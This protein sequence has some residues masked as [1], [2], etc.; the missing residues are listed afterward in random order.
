MFF[1]H[2]LDKKFAHLKFLIL[3]TKKSHSKE[4]AVPHP[5]SFEKSRDILDVDDVLKQ[6]ES[7]SPE[8]I[9]QIFGFVE[10]ELGSILQYFSP[11][12]GLLSMVERR[13]NSPALNACALIKHLQ[14][15]EEEYEELRTSLSRRYDKYTRLSMELR[16]YLYLLLTRGSV[17]TSWNGRVGI[18]PVVLEGILDMEPGRQRNIYAA[19]SDL[20]FVDVPEGEYP[21][22]LYLLWSTPFNIDLFLT[23]REMFGIDSDEL[24]RL[25]LD[26]DFTLLDA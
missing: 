6:I 17:T 11:K 2:E 1:A 10:R 23:F 26:G 22:M 19:L 16:E 13:I 8:I 12:Q 24:K 4:F 15:E 20:G 25:L 3:T 7:C 5:F 9:D 21:P 14:I 18:P